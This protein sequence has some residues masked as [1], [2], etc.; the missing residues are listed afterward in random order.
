VPDFIALLPLPDSGDSVAGGIY[1]LFEYSA[2]VVE[3]G[4]LLQCGSKEQYAAV[5][6]GGDH[7]LPYRTGNFSG[8]FHSARSAGGPIDMGLSGSALNSVSQISSELLKLPPATL[9][10]SSLV[11]ATKSPMHIGDARVREDRLRVC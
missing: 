2:G 10:R 1:F 8:Q 4:M 9:A 3:E 7:S 5:A 6:D 11:H